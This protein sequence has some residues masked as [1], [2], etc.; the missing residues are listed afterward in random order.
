MG[1]GCSLEGRLSY[2][3]QEVR[4][5]PKEKIEPQKI[6]FSLLKMSLPNLTLRFSDLSINPNGSERF[7]CPEVPWFLMQMTSREPPTPHVPTMLSRMIWKVRPSVC[8]DLR[9]RKSAHDMSWRT[10]TVIL[11]CNSDTNHP[12]LVPTPKTQGRSPT[13][14]P[15]LQMPAARLGFPRLP[16]LLTN[17]LQT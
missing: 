7:S 3:L 2:Q 12:E 4:W 11:Q 14:L 10:H 13:T 17:W 1:P 15:W 9:W 16:T 8:T 6:L 5:R